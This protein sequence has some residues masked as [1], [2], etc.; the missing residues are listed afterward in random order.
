MKNSSNSKHF[1]LISFFPALAYTYLEMN[2]SLKIA[3]IGGLGLATLEMAL[4]K[5]FTRHIHTISKLNFWLIVI[6]GVLSLSGDEGIWFKLQPMFTGVIF[7][8]VILYKNYRG[9]SLFIEMSEAMG[10]NRLPDFLIKIME[11]H[12][13][14][15]FGMYGVFMGVIAFTQSTPRWLFYKTVG[16]YI[17]AA[18]FVV[19]EVIFMRKKVSSLIIKNNKNL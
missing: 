10:K 5:I 6:L 13:A 15:F 1:F 18:L 16:F 19:I 3:V 14:F 7:S 4:E 12:F 17:A 9:K 2:Y 11:K 8:L